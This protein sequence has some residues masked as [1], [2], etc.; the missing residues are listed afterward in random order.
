MCQGKKVLD[1]GCGYG[2]FLKRIC[3]VADECAG[4]ELGNRERDYLNS[5]GIR[6]LKS[7]DEYNE[8]FDVITLFHVFEH[9]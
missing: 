2:G 7:I 9:L 6:C 4:V 8:K 3:D 1:F 5:S